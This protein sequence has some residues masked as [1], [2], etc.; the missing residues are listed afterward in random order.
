MT[1]LEK[2]YVQSFLIS[3]ILYVLL[4]PLFLNLFQ[5]LH[6]I[7]FAVIWCCLT[8]IVFFVV[9]GVRNEKIIL[10][11]Q[12]FITGL[13]LYTIS[14]IILLFLRPNNQHYDSF[15][16]VPFKTVI[17]YLSGQ[18]KPLIAFYNLLANVGLFVP[19]GISFLLLRK[20]SRSSV[21][22][23]LGVPLLTIILIE[24]MQFFTHRGSLDVDDLIL[25]IAGVGLGYVLFPLVRRVLI[26]N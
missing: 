5:Y 16:L 2:S 13:V 20:T 6:T 18:V 11:K 25:N 7:V 12:V 3:Q 10:S 8:S 22:F 23:L 4:F 17:F 24:C 21:S 9:Y 1:L 26:I 15:N 14:L 19:Y